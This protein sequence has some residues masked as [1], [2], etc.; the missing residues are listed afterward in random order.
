MVLLLLFDGDFT[1]PNGVDIFVYADRDDL[2]ILDRTSAGGD[3]AGHNII[4]NNVEEFEDAFTTATD[5]IVL[6]FDTFENLSVSNESG[7]IQK[8][9]VSNGGGQGYTKLPTVSVTST[10]GQN[11][12]LSA[13]T[14]NIGA[15][16]SIQITDSGFNYVGTNPPDA[17][18]NLLC[19]KD[20]SGT[21]ANGN[22]LTSHTGT[23][24]GYDSNTRVLDT[25]FENV[26]RVEQE[27]TST[28]N[29]GIELEQG[30]QVNASSSILLE[31][32]LEF[33]DGENIILDGTETFTPLQTI[34]KKKFVLVEMQLIL[35]TSFIL[36]MNHRD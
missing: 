18:L 20:V 27:Q 6:E 30:T 24:K 4:T 31:D 12:V 25:T 34:T 11:A 13:T 19:F 10:S 14:E 17:T 22:T 15:V 26:V 3:D 23:V 16:K 29:E 2:L 8:V 5:Q 36:M 33:D 21:F 9:F 7:S 1:P 32:V 28:F 35:Q